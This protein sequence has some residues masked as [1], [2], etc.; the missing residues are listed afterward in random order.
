MTILFLSGNDCCCLLSCDLTTVRWRHNWTVTSF[1]VA[2]VLNVRWLG[3][4][5]ALFL[6]H[7]ILLLCKWKQKRN[8]SCVR[9]KKHIWRI[10]VNFRIFP[11]QIRNRK[12]HADY[13]LSFFISYKVWFGGKTSPFISL[14]DSGNA[15][16]QSSEL[17]TDILCTFSAEN[18]TRKVLTPP[19][20]STWVLLTGNYGY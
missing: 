18:R 14:K 15:D 13:V 9:D 17:K 16:L 4:V 12:S 11:A 8:F 2:D 19:L 20:L 1:S 7:C 5:Y 10:R 3:Q 6:F